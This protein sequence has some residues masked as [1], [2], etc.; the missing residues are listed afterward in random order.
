[1]PAFGEILLRVINDPIRAD[2]SNHLHILRTAYADHIRAERSGDLHSERAHASRRTVNQGLL[3]RLI[4]PLSRIP[5]NAVIAAT[6][7]EAACSKVTLSG[8]MTNAD[9]MPSAD[10]EVAYSAKARGTCRT[11]RRPV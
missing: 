2:G 3:P 5:C 7:A 9:F 4:R 11:P 1:L 10:S 6:G 8:F